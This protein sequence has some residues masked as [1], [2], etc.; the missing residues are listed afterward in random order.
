LI[1]FLKDAG[2]FGKRVGE[3]FAHS[4]ELGTLTWE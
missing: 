3:G 4:G 1:R 2:G